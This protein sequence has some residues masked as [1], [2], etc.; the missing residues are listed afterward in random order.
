MDGRVIVLHT[1]PEQEE[2]LKTAVLAPEPY[3]CRRK[4]S[5]PKLVRSGTSGMPGKHPCK[6]TG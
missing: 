5:A 6:R 4:S 3:G 2:R 1:T